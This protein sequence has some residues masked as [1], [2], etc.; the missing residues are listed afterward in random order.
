MTT[1]VVPEVVVAETVNTFRI[2]LDS[3]RKK[4]VDDLAIAEKLTGAQ[5]LTI[6]LDVQRESD[7]YQTVSIERLDELGAVSGSS[8]RVDSQITLRWLP[9]K[10]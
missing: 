8:L 3:A 10:R 9:I 5:I 4:A 7:R 6:D 2:K 1:L